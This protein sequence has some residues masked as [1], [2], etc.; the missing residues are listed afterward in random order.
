MTDIH[1]YFAVNYYPVTTHF[2]FSLNQS[3]PIVEKVLSRE[4]DFC[5]VIQVYTTGKYTIVY[6][7][8]STNKLS[9]FGFDL[10]LKMDIYTRT[11]Y[12]LEFCKMINQQYDY[13]HFVD[14]FN[15]F[16]MQL[17]NCFKQE[18][19]V[20]AEMTISE[21]YTLRDVGMDLPSKR[22]CLFP[23]LDKLGL[24]RWLFGEN[25]KHVIIGRVT[26]RRIYLV[27]DTARNL[28][29]IENRY[30]SSLKDSGIGNTYDL[31]T[32]WEAPEWEIS[33]LHQLFK[34]KRILKSWFHLSFEDLKYIKDR[35]RDYK[36]S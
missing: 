16:Q 29:G 13:I 30:Y 10:N 31:I 12:T 25:E 11:E 9:G 35:M 4:R 28:I 8:Y 6:I 34:K 7:D 15:S 33:R 20:S 23:R 3:H 2:I 22:I 18:G 17:S 32:S 14:I 27:L 36:V 19:Y 24:Y 1:R 26:K 21:L 5:C